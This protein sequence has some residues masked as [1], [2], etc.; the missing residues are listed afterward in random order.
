MFKGL[1]DKLGFLLMKKE[2]KVKVIEALRYYNQLAEIQS[3]MNRISEQVLT[4]IREQGY[5]P[6]D[7][8]KGFLQ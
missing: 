1:R 5:M 4:E 7:E 6:Q 8:K 2:T 3:E